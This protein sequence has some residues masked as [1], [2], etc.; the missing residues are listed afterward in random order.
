MSERI[1]IHYELPESDYR[2][3]TAVC[4]SDLKVLDRSPAHLL[5]RIEPEE[6][7]EDSDAIMMGKIAGSIALEPGRSPWWVVQPDGLKLNTTEGR[8]WAKEHENDYIVPFK[9]FRRACG[10]A[11]AVLDHPIASEILKNAKREVSMFERMETECGPVRVKGR[12]DILTEGN[13]ITDLKST[14]DARVEPFS[15]SVERFGYDVQAGFYIDLWNILNP[16]DRKE[17]YLL[18]AVESLPPFAVQVHRLSSEYI[19]AGRLKYRRLLEVYAK[20]LTTNTWPGYP[21]EITTITPKN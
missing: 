20:C 16:N 21:V 8:A 15:G 1:G 11:T 12:L 9:L 10:M 7:K 3:D 6:Q 13:V 17:V 5:A 2:A 18:I 19:A 4:Q 14:R